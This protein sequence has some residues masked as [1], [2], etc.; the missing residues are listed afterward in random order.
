MNSSIADLFD[1]KQRIAL[2]T[3]A[4]VGI[5]AKIAERL[6]EAGACVGVVDIDVEGANRTAE[7]IRASGG[8][9]QAFTCD[10]ARM[11]QVRHTVKKVAAELGRIDILVNNAGVFPVAPALELTETSWDRVLDINLK[12]AFFMAQC[13]AEHMLQQGDGGSIVNIA[14]IDGLHPSGRLVH[15]DASKGGLIMMTRSLA[16]ELGGH[17][18]RVNA[19]APG[20]IQTPGAEA[21]M[22]AMAG[23]GSAAQ[24]K[25]QFTSRI[26]LG[27]M[28]EP[29]D[30]AK[31]VLFLASRAADYITGSTLVVDGGYLLS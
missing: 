10:V 24:V 25:S 19:V 2:V 28:G 23:P 20:A 30:I 3:G 27:R 5:G 16:L 8:I 9:A 14:S 26:P 4:A 12:G 18:I 21:A 13:A 15:Y 6:A 22:S 7:R 1:L 11:D 17:R 29:D 31:A